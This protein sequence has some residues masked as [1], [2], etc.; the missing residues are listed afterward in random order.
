[1]PHRVVLTDEAV[2]NLIEIGDYIA[3]DNPTAARETI[4]RLRSH[5]TALAEFP[6]RHRVR[7]RLG[8]DRRVMVVGS[9][10]VVYCIDSH[11]VYIER[12]SEGSRNMQ[13]LLE[14]DDR[15]RT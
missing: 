6:K 5:I 4:I 12:V 15:G 3:L 2:R 10:L 1:M 7:V 9:Y 14:D 13:Q 11:S 8:R